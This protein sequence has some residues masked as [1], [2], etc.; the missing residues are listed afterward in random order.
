MDVTV[1]GAGVVGGALIASFND[2][3]KVHII[4]PAHP[5][6]T[7]SIKD[8]T[9]LSKIIFLCLPTPTMDNGEIDIL[10]FNSYFVH[11][12]RSSYS[13]LVVIK[14][15][16]TPQ[17]LEK[18][19]RD[20]PTLRLVYFPEFLTEA[21]PLSDMLHPSVHIMGG[22]DTDLYAMHQFIIHKTKIKEC[23]VYK[24][25]IITASLAKYFINSWLATKVLFMNEFY[26]LQQQS[27][28]SVAW[29]EFTNIVS[30][31]KRVGD[32]HLKVP[33]PD[34][35]MGFGG[36]CFPKDTVALLTYA[37]ECGIDLTVLKAAVETNKDIR[38]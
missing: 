9:A 2:D 1:I 37:K 34:G 17:H 21:N 7:R 35:K 28:S 24:T 5:D 19:K 15:T 13:G 27:N 26:A 25:D 11:L 3:V 22:E 14:S 38:K 20:H 36:M 32:S 33:G 18:F 29:A 6:T 12:D 10:L 23:P 16:L 4:D 30:T 31:D 8:A